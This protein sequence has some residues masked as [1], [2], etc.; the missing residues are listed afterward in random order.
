[1]EKRPKVGMKFNGHERGGFKRAPTVHTVLGEERACL[2]GD[3]GKN[4]EIF[5]KDSPVVEFQR[6]QVTLWVDRAEVA[7]IFGPPVAIEL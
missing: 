1:M 5:G 7:P 2:M 6:G 3:I 4:G